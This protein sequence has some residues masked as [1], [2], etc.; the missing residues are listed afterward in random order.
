MKAALF[1]GAVVLAA[2]KLQAAPA[3]ACPGV[4]SALTEQVPLPHLAAALKPGGTP[5]PATLN[6]LALGSATLFGPQTDAAA[7]LSRDPA[8]PGQAAPRQAAQPAGAPAPGAA[9][10]GSGSAAVK[11]AAPATAPATT[12][13]PWQMAQALQAAVKNLHVAVTFVGGHGLPADAMLA[14][15]QAELSR[16][17][18]Q[19]VIWQTGTVEAVSEAAPDDFYQTLSDGAAAVAAA[20]A[21]LV[22]VNPQYS[23][24][25]EA[26]ANVAPYLSA[27]Q[28]AAA[29]PGVTLFDRYGIMHDWVDDDA[30]DLERAADADRPALAA[31]LHLCLG[32]TLAAMLRG[33]AAGS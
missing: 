15:L 30:L 9:M 23:R 20:G 28:A 1:A 13:F 7:D 26:N 16:H 18:Y 2:A 24:F 29:L 21:D 31:R 11:H 5:Q 19:L 33:D 32:R 6:V 17:K 10:P 12:G 8:P 25:L 4:D 22:L 14:K 27:L 3:P